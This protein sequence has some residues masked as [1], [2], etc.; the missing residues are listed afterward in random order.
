MNDFN[1]KLVGV[2]KGDK[3][4]EQTAPLLENINE[5]LSRY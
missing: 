2:K 3:V 5:F 4:N 1:K